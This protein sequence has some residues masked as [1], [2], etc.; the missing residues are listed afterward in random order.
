MSLRKTEKLAGWLRRGGGRHVAA[1][2][3]YLTIAL[4]ALRAVLPAPASTLPYPLDA[5]PARWKLLNI[6]DQ[7]LTAWGVSRNARTILT[8]PGALFQA[9]QCYPLQNSLTLGEHMV[10]DG[11]LGALPYLLTRNPILTYNAVALLSLWLAAAAM[12]SLTYYWTQSAAASFVAGLLFGFH[13]SR[14]GDLVH[15]HVIHNQWTPLAILFADRLFTRRRWRDALGLTLF[16]CLGLL[17]SFYQVLV[18]AIIGAG[19][20]AYLLSR[21]L[22]RLVSLLP[23]LALFLAATAALAYAVFFP[24]LRTKSLWGVLEGRGRILNNPSDFAFGAGAYPGSVLLLLASIGLFVALARKGEDQRA[25]PRLPLAI[26]SL[27]LLWAST[28]SLPVPLTSYRIP[29]LYLLAGEALPGLGAV[30]APAAVRSG[31]YLVGALFAGMGLAWILENLCG[32]KRGAATVLLS[33]AALAEIFFPPLSRLSFAKTLE[34]Q[35]Y[36]ARPLPGVV[37]LYR[38]QAPG[39]IL[40]LPLSF[41]K[42]GFIPWM[43]HYVFM[44]AFHHQPVAACYNSFITDVQWEIERLAKRLPDPVAADALYGLGFRTVMLHYELLS[45]SGHLIRMVNMPSSKTHMVKSGQVL[46]HTAFRLLGT[47]KTVADLG[48]LEA[49]TEGSLFPEIASPPEALV[50]FR[51]RNRSQAIFIHPAPIEPTP[52]L[53]SWRDGSGRVVKQEAT[54]ALLPLALGPGEEAIRRLRV[55]VPR[56]MGAYT[57]SLAP[58]GQPALVLAKREVRVAKKSFVGKGPE[59]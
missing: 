34:Y 56:K 36:L 14:L 7:S 23:K 41:T 6:G 27:L 18:L 25:D 45:T 19:Y 32:A 38:R 52:L 42:V 17:G 16:V 43:P 37:E 59:K 12:Y 46:F 47:G 53:V 15:L 11:L 48:V 54:K 13:P 39:P 51:L 9:E 44:S 3:L 31:I 8:A 2:L 20:G 5:G 35:P 33:G 50:A 26:C 10:G 49:G 29:S 4:W 21:T 40:D 24:Y 58:A 1:L 57:V 28:V 22:P 30:R 55:E